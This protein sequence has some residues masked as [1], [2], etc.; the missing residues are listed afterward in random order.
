MV[1]LFEIVQISNA[2]LQMSFTDK[3]SHL[4]FVINHQTIYLNQMSDQLPVLY[5]NTDKFHASSADFLENLQGNHL[6]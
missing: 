2:L 6:T 5:L 4:Q 1:V 3:L